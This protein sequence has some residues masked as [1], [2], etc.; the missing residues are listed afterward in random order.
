MM[1]AHLFYAKN[2][3]TFRELEAFLPPPDY[4]N[5]Q[6]ISRI[7]WLTNLADAKKVARK[8]NKPIFI[9]FTGYTCIN[10]R[11][12][13]QNIFTKKEVE[14]I[15]LKEFVLVRLY[16]D[17]DGSDY[18]KNQQYQNKKFN[19]VALPLYALLT[20]EELIISTFEGMTRDYEKFIKFLRSV[21]PKK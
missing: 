11:W 14:N 3:Q 2:G 19:T 7:H 12:M 5:T 4:G 6:Y 1:A 13:E 15:L 16:T 17:G 21:Q 10:C 8:Q 9:D 20:P 18:I